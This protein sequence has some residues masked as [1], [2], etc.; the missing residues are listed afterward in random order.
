MAVEPFLATK[1]T[2]GMTCSGSANCFIEDVDNMD[3][4]W[5]I[6]YVNPENVVDYEVSLRYPNPFYK[7]NEAAA[8]G[9]VVYT[10]LAAER[11]FG[12][13]VCAVFPIV[14]R[15][16]K[17]WV[18]VFRRGYRDVFDYVSANL[19]VYDNRQYPITDTISN[20][21]LKK[22][23]IA[24]ENG[25]IL[26]DIKTENMV[27]STP[28][29]GVDLRFIDFDPQFTVLI[30][31]P[32]AFSVECVYLLNLM[33]FCNSVLK[34]PAAYKRLGNVIAVELL[35]HWVAMT[36]ENTHLYAMFVEIETF[37]LA[38]CPLRLMSGMDIKSKLLNTN[39]IQ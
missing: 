33:L 15:E 24:S 12:A 25:M 28:G 35:R 9:E 21:I 38:D 14:T 29:R 39:V 3:P 31:P 13:D 1:R 6:S 23:T 5:M 4:K 26:G 11:G 16:R 36:T 18:Y 19:N 22:L 2:E 37:S 7:P 10:L 27:I 30:D 8:A 17:T 20:E 32:G 34:R